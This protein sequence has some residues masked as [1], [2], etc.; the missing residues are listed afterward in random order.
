MR[1]VYTATQEP[2]KAG[3]IH[4]INGET[5]YVGD[6]PP[7]HKPDSE[8]KVQLKT[9]P[10]DWFGMDRYVSV[11]GAEWIEREDRQ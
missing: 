6:F 11:I 5:F 4:K 3:D 10:Y 8:G 9:H 1:L 7:P 2:V